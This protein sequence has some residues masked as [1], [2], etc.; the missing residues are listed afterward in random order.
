MKKE[1]NKVDKT[2]KSNLSNK[3]NETKSEPEVQENISNPEPQTPEI[4]SPSLST[5]RV[6]D[7]IPQE[8]V[9]EEKPTSHKVNIGKGHKYGKKYKEIAKLVEKGKIYPLTEAVELTKKT[10]PTKFDATIELHLRLNLGKK[11]AEGL[12]GTLTLPVPVAG[13]KKIIAAFV[14]PSKEKEAKEA[15]AEFVGG[16]E[17]VEK[18]AGGWLGFDIAVAAPMMMPKLAKV[19]KTL[20]PKGLMPNPKVGTVSEEI[21]K[22]IEEIFKGKQEW[23]TDSFGIAHIS[24]GK[25]SMAAEDIVK[26]INVVLEAVSKILPGARSAIVKSMAIASTMGPAIRV[27]PE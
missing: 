26:N 10:S 18:V 7:Q 21:G 25:V 15:G 8:S 12:R 22:V 1:S 20:G 17:L 24:V 11:A 27:K 13:K 16:E 5:R 19:A 3:S 2:N 4:P 6:G 14:D 23:K 9:E